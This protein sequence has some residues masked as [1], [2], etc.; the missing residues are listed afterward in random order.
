MLISVASNLVNLVLNLLFVWDWIRCGGFCLRDPS[1]K[2]LRHDSGNVQTEESAAD[3]ISTQV[4]ILSARLGR[5][6]EDPADRDPV[7]CGEQ[8]V[9]VR[10]TGDPVHGVSDGNCC[11]RGTG[12]ASIV[13]NLN[14]ILGIGVGIGLMTVVGETLGAGRREEAVLLCKEAVHHF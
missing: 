12:I 6:Q 1:G 4:I 14:G 3:G 9:P 8:H 2:D 10:E 11:D 13:E 5:D 7:R